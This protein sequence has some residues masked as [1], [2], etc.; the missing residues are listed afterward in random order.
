MTRYLQIIAAVL[1]G[2]VTPGVALAQDEQAPQLM[3]APIETFTCNYVD[4]KGP[5]DLDGV[6]DDWNKW[7]DKKKLNQY[8]AMT[9][10]PQYFGANYRFDV[11][12]LGAW[13][14]G[15]AM[16]RETDVWTSEGADVAAKF[17]SV[18]DCDTHSNF[19]SVQLKSPGEGPAPD[20]LVVTFSDC[21]IME[22]VEFDDLMAALNEWSAY[23]EEKGYGN[24]AWILFPVYGGGGAEFDFKLV[25]GYDSYAELGADYDRY[26]NGGDYVKFDEL[27]GGKMEC[28]DARVYDGIVRRRSAPQ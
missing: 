9:M 10:T 20:K 26:G 24:G 18:V 4:G 27:L 22:G 11:G 14:D 6:I 8:F 2:I 25:D 3:V 28:D 13:T 23:Q 12:W 1:P 21:N 5:A 15:A 19:A 16:G 17:A 7:S